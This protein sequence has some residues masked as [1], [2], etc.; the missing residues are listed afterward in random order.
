MPRN[1]RREKTARLILNKTPALRSL[2]TG[3]YRIW[4]RQNEPGKN[5]LEE[6]KIKALAFAD[7]PLISIVVPV[8]SPPLKVLHEMVQSV[9]AQSYQNWELCLA[10]G[11]TTSSIIQRVLETYAKQDKRIRVKA[12]ETNQG[13]AGNTNAA[14]EMAQGS[15]IG[16]LDHDDCLAPFAL[17]EVVSAINQYSETDLLY[18]DE[19]YLSADGKRRY[20]P[21]FKPIL[22]IDYLRAGNYMPHFLVLR[23]ELGDRLGWLRLGFDGAQDYDLILRTV[24]RAR[25][26]THIPQV[27]Y[28]W[29][30]LPTSTASTLDAKTYAS[31]AGLRAISEH[32][33]RCD[34]KGTVQVGP[35]PTIY[36]MRYEIPTPS[37]VSIII[38]NHEHAK[39]LRRCVDSI[40]SQTIYQHYEIL[41]VEN[42]SQSED[43][44]ALY[45][46]LQV[47]D[48]RV[49]VLEYRHHPFNYSEINNFA[50][51]LSTGSLLVFL[52]ND[53]EVIS[54]NWLERMLEYAQRPDVG[55]VGAKLYFPNNLIQHAGLIVGMGVGAGH[56]FV[57]YP[58]DYPGYR[59]N[60]LL[61]QNLS[62]VTAACLMI[63]K[64]VFDE[65][66][67]FDPNYQLGYGD[68]DLCLKLRQK[69]YLVVWTPHA[70]LIH[71][72]SL[73]R[74]YEDTP[75]K[76]ARF[77]REAKL[78]M[79]KWADFFAAGD[80]Y[81][82]P[83]LT[84]SRGDF[85]LRAGVCNQT[86]RP[87]RGLLSPRASIKKQS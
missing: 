13:I 87:A 3:N 70:E 26:V 41:I 53:T 34:L 28:H 84:L 10:N 29:R 19:D 48:K 24:E 74:G 30:A 17:Y 14:I 80:P 61:P 73:T 38:P 85:S 46:Q 6:Q 40:L 7:R 86:P 43:I 63:R 11:E 56:Y 5:S 75:E 54:P 32:L 79:T 65:V 68:I 52:N 76:E 31:E 9:L 60:L 23:K 62:A 59:Y 15:F 47:Q 8:F 83:N 27:L 72:E 33:E 20:N 64:E 44:F 21:V 58:R 57:G 67:G 36:Q 1:S 51:D 25:W 66:G 42:N 71:H 49:R 16:F 55:A 82:N 12:L 50:V 45:R 18:S 4:I 37:L 78:L 35:T 22:S 77:Y 69:D 2:L 39:D 81:Y